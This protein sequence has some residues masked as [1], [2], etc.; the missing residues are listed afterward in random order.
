MIYLIL[1]FAEYAEYILMKPNELYAPYMDAIREKI[2]LS[3]VVIELLI[4]DNEA[5][6]EDLLNK[7]DVKWFLVHRLFINKIFF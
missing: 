7:L 4:E 5:S 1:Y 6:Y 2:H 3:K